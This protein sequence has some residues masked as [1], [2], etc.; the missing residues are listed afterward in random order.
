MKSQDQMA[1]WRI[2]RT[3]KEKP[4]PIFILFYKIEAN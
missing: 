1:A 4:N 2:L 3:F